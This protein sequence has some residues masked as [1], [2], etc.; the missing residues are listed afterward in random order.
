MLCPNETWAELTRI[1]LLESHS[2]R[3]TVCGFSMHPAIK[4]RDVIHIRRVTSADIHLGDVVLYTVHG[5]PLIHRVVRI[6]PRS[7]PPTFYICSDHQARGDWV[8]A[9]HIIGKVSAV[10]RRARSISLESPW[11]RLR[12]WL[13]YGLRIP[14]VTLWNRLRRWCITRHVIA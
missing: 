10:E 2:I 12:N 14:R 5:R 8:A 11:G 9:A 4:D 13:F 3:V 7:Q 1:L 6:A